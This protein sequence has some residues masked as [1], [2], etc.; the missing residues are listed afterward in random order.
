M[1]FY[2]LKGVAEIIVESIEAVKEFNESDC[3]SPSLN[4]SRPSR[5]FK[6]F[7]KRDPAKENIDKLI[8]VSKI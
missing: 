4:G 3:L 6:S 8:D 7:T 1:D 2:D 5:D